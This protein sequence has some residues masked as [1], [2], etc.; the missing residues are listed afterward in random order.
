MVVGCDRV[1]ATSPSAGESQP[2]ANSRAAIVIGLSSGTGT[3]P[4]RIVFKLDRW[5]S[6]G[7]D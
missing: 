4:A 6:R 7:F 2:C 1:N 5:P 3:I